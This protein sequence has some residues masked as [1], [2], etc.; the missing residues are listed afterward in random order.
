VCGQ[1]PPPH[2]HTHTQPLSEQSTFLTE[3]FYQGELGGQEGGS[4]SP[5]AGLSNTRQLD[6]HTEAFAAASSSHTH[7]HTDT[8]TD[9]QPPSSAAPELSLPA[10]KPP[11]EPTE[12][13][14]TAP[15][16]LR[17]PEPQVRVCV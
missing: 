7:T 17:A 13:P 9:T 5:D 15:S 1:P 8:R 3:Q 4:T 10:V 2:T 12:Q 16:V 11:E 14:A 6:L